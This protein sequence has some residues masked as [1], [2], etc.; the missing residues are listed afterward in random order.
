MIVLFLAGLP[1]GRLGLYLQPSLLVQIDAEPVKERIGI[2]IEPL[3]RKK[4][5]TV[6]KLFLRK[7]KSSPASAHPPGFWVSQLVTHGIERIAV[8]QG[9]TQVDIVLA[10]HTIGNPGSGHIIA[11]EIDR[12]P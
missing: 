8:A 10:E 3:A 5:K 9:K 2:L 7:V 11:P 12:H 1:V 4:I 6:F